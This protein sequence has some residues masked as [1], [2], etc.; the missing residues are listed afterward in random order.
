M[1]PFKQPL[2]AAA[3]QRRQS[4]A[5]RLHRPDGVKFC[6]LVS[7]PAYKSSGAGEAATSVASSSSSSPVRVRPNAAA[8]SAAV[9]AL[10]GLSDVTYQLLSTASLPP[11]GM[12]LDTVGEAAAAAGVASASALA[13]A[14]LV[15]RDTF[16]LEWH[17]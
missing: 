2:T 16:H 7:I 4:C 14:K 12:V 17:K 15:L 6:R 13:T 9:L 10:A 8:V 11:L 5:S 1:L 3:G